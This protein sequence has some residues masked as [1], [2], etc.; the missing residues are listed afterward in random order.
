MMR[1]TRRAAL[2]GMGMAGLLARPALAQQGSWPARSV[3]L[4]VAYPPGGSTDIVGRLLAERLGR[5]WGQPVVV[6]NR[7]G[8]SGTL[9]A[10]SVAKAAPDG[11]TLLLGASSE[12]AIAPVT[13]RQLPYDVARDFAPIGRTS[14][15][16]FLLLVNAQMPVRTVAELVALAKAR[17]G[18]LNYASFGNGTSTHLMGELFRVSTGIEITH[19]PY[20]GSAPGIAD[21]IAGQIQMSF[22]TVP[23]GTP[24]IGPGGKLRAL[25]FTHARRSAAAPEVPTMPEVGFPQL[26]GSTW[27]ALVAPAGTPEPV[28]ARIGADLARIKAEGFNAALV[29]R[30]IEPVAETSAADARGFFAAEAAKW[31]DVAQKAGVRPE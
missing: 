26:V 22:D 16:P 20:R 18:T 4:V 25:G 15:Q 29:E 8:A 31:A 11:Y 23:A 3:K 1:I 27:S 19:V 28:L 21:L 13:F 12:M 2:A 17:P 6:E 7:A 5:A 30:G 24:H 10:D 14:E 9:G